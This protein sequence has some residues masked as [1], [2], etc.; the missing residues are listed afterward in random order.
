L[1]LVR[2]LVTQILKVF[3]LY[4]YDTDRARNPKFSPCMKGIWIESLIKHIQD[5]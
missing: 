3:R 4:T 5:D 1:S 2:L